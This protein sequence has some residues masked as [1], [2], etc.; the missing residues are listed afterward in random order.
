MAQAKHA[1][2]ALQTPLSPLQLELLKLYS[3]EMTSSELLELKRVLARYFATKATAAADQAWDE[4]GLSNE[5]MDAWL[6]G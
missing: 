1:P 5:D 2:T 3:T 6:H 4:R